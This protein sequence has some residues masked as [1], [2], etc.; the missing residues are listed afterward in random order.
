MNQLMFDQSIWESCFQAAPGQEA[1]GIVTMSFIW[2]AFPLVFGTTFGLGA[3]AISSKIQQVPDF[4]ELLRP[5]S[6]G[7]TICLLMAS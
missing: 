1:L 4:G 5:V 3:L 7:V 6:S 2:F